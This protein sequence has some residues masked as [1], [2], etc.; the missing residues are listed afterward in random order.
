MKT[1]KV[2]AVWQE[3]A[4]V[5]APGETLAD[6]IKTVADGNVKLP[7]HGYHVDGSLE[8]D[9]SATREANDR[10]FVVN[11]GNSLSGPIGFVLNIDAG[12]YDD[13]L[14][15]AKKLLAGVE[16]N[17]EIRQDALSKTSDTPNL[18]IYFNPDFLELPD[19]EEG[20]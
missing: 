17:V 8:V 9:E 18:H 16:V 12:S 3:T 5:D 1:H 6:S 14:K 7:E 4:V 11:A 20:E 19:V 13:A 2:V 10:P 15:K